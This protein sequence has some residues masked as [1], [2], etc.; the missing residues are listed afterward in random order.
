M[1]ASASGECH[2]CLI[3]FVSLYRSCEFRTSLFHFRGAYH[4]GH[5]GEDPQAQAK[6]FVDTVGSL[7]NGE[8]LVLDIE[9]ASSNASLHSAQDVASWSKDFVDA[10]CSLTNLPPSRVLIYTG[11]WFW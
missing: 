1:P 3:C 4:F 6:Y 2:I 11:A 8:V 9:V 10:V 7:G 5:P